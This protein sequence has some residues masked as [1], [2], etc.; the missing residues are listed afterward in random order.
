MTS[1][2]V[3][4]VEDTEVAASTLEIAL[5]AIPGIAVRVASSGARALDLLHGELAALLTDLNMP[6]VDGFEL[7][8]RLRCDPRHCRLPIIVISGDTDPATP[9]KV[10]ALGANAFFG[11]PFSPALVRAKLEELLQKGEG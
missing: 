1:R 8:E 5:M 2:T 9:G 11:K 10:L 7:I 4:I 3:L 6:G